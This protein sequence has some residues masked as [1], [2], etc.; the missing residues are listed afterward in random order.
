MIR[1][2]MERPQSG[3]EPLGKLDY[4]RKLML[5]ISDGAKSKV[6]LG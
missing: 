6:T 1:S 2:W 4:S 5:Q 3:I